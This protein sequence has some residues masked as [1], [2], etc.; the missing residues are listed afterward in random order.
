MADMPAAEFRV[1]GVLHVDDPAGDQD[2]QPC[3][4]KVLHLNGRETTLQQGQEKRNRKRWAK[5]TWQLV[6][7]SGLQRNSAVTERTAGV[8]TS[9]YNQYSWCRNIILNTSTSTS[10]SY[11]TSSCSC[12]SW[13]ICFKLNII[14]RIDSFYFLS[15]FC[16]FANITVSKD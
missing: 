9:G 1:R 16:Y 3:Q 6:V 13:F 14:Y 2:A 11:V 5:R 10:T 4:E 7:E 12:F 8:L 15:R